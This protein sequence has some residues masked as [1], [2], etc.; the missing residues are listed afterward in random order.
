MLFIKLINDFC[1]MIGRPSISKCFEIKVSQFMWTN[2]SHKCNFARQNYSLK[3]Y[4]ESTQIS[5][6][7]MTKV[8]VSTKLRRS[9]RNKE[10]NEAQK[11][12]QSCKFSLNSY[13]EEHVYREKNSL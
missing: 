12:K 10:A 9:C 11:I 2:R 4:L 1:N 7:L 13:T 6:G 8:P 3:V 5:N